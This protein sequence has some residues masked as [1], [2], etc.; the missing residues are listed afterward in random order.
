[1]SV[2]ISTDLCLILSLEHNL[3]LSEKK[4]ELVPLHSH[5]N[6]RLSTFVNHFAYVDIAMPRFRLISNFC[7]MSLTN[8]HR[9][10][11]AKLDVMRRKAQG[12]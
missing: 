3:Y 2:Y 4:L 5:L 12:K 6:E 10:S 9:V 7:G 8:F 1:M 11:L